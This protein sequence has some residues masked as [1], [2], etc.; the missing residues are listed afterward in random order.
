[1]DGH[2]HV[3][4]VAVCALACARVCQFMCVYMWV[5]LSGRVPKCVRVC[6]LCI[7]QDR[8]GRMACDLANELW[9]IWPK[10][11]S[12]SLRTASD[13][14][15][16]AYL[17]LHFHTHVCVSSRVSVIGRMLVGGCADRW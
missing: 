1:M 15:H 13:L 11:A 7:T 14:L 17:H 3:L 12:V 2:S 16:D 8:R 6:R 4:I 5:L 9:P 10:G